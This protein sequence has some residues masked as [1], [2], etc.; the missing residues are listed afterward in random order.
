TKAIG[1]DFVEF[2][3]DSHICLNPFQIIKN[4]NE[5]AD[6]LVGIIVSMAAMEDKLTDL[7]LARLRSIL[8]ELWNQH[9]RSM[10][11]DQVAERLLQDEDRRVADMGHQLFAFTSDGEYGRFFNG[12]N[13]VNFNNTLTCLELEELKGRSHLQ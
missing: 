6:M 11:V 4:Y 3:E 9:E 7:Q 8:K 10:T 2:G 1:G 12:K 13:N 5:E